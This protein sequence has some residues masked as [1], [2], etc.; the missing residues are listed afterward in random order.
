MHTFASVSAI[1][2]AGKL[3]GDVSIRVAFEDI[4]VTRMKPVTEYYFANGQRVAMRKNG[5][6]TYLLTDQLGSTSLAVDAS[7]VKTAEM[8]Y[9]PWGEVR[10]AWSA[11]PGLP[12]NYTYTGQR[13][14]MDDPTT[15]TTEGFGLMYYGARWYDNYLN[16]FTQ[17]DSIIPDQ[18]NSVDYDRYSYARN[19]PVKYT[20]PSGHRVTPGCGDGRE[21]CGAS[22]REKAQAEYQRQRGNGLKCQGGNKTYCSYAENHPVE[23]VGYGV[24]GLALAS[25]GAAAVTYTTMTAGT[26]ATTTTTV[27]AAEAACGGD[28]S[29]EAQE[30]GSAVGN[31]LATIEQHLQQYG[32]DGPNE[33][34]LNR[35][36][37]GLSTSWDQAFY[38][39][40]MMEAQNMLGSE[41]TYEAQRAAHLLTLAQHGIPYEAG[42]EAYLY[43]PEVIDAFPEYFN[44][45]TQNISMLRR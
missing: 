27:G 16:H 2:I 37:N 28:C 42:Y 40:E 26:M 1:Y 3:I 4:F 44:L 31:G 32:A 17:P 23:T 19:N 12:T 15:T 13:T 18:Y 10:Y 24:T 14:Y 35:L 29:D 8:R 43:H 21:S 39:H 11:I 41:P 5:A 33:A 38:Q 34:M 9:K 36:K 30:A 7:G 25:I 20:D 45:A 6:V 22:E